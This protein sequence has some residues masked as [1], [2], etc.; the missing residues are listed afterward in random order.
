MYEERSGMSSSWTEGRPLQMNYSCL[1]WPT[2]LRWP[3]PPADLVYISASLEHDMLIISF[4]IYS[5]HKQTMAA[6]LQ[7]L[8]DESW[9]DSSPSDD[10]ILRR[11][12]PHMNWARSAPKQWPWEICKVREMFQLDIRWNRGSQVFRGR[13]A[14]DSWPCF[15]FLSPEHLPASAV[16]I[17]GQKGLQLV[18]LEV[19]PHFTGMDSEAED[20][21]SFLTFA[22]THLKLGDGTLFCQN[23]FIQYVTGHIHGLEWFHLWYKSNQSAITE[24]KHLQKKKLL[25]EK[26][27]D[28]NQM[29]GHSPDGK[30][31]CGN[32][33]PVS[34]CFYWIVQ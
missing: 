11:R 7:R 15:T 20:L 19:P 8:A 5:A 4:P 22:E 34:M 14:A 13:I 29:D 30:V 21:C 26:E 31:S 1:I 24:H 32:L 23:I 25:M 3:N 17:S 16:S 33:F 2:S 10:R 27:S 9:L 28:R 12:S 6:A 18:W